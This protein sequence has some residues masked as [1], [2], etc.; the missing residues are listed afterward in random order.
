MLLVPAGKFRYGK[1]ARQLELPAFYIDRTEVTIEAWRRYCVEHGCPTVTGEASLPVTDITFE[2]A[3]TF[4]ET[5]GKRLPTSQEW[6]KAARGIDGSPYPWGAEDRPGAAN[7]STNPGEDRVEPAG[8][9]VAGASPFG[10]LDM[11]GNVWEF[12]MD[13]RTPSAQDVALFRRLGVKPP[14]TATEPWVAIY[15]GSYAGPL[16]H[17]GDA[18]LV[19]ARYSD[20]TIGFRCAANP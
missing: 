12:V 14:V 13:S 20:R 2:A 16:S 9:H 11:A 4:C 17:M 6:E 19:P 7:V 1:E 15:G 18:A 8:S 5:V 3:R 10:A